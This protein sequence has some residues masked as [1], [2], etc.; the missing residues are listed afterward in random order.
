MGGGDSCTVVKKDVANVLTFLELGDQI[1]EDE[2]N[3]T[4]IYGAHCVLP[5]C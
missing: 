3:I 5:P 4:I 1:L 2:R